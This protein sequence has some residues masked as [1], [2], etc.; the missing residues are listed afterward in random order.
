MVS[1]IC[2]PGAGIEAVT[3]EIANLKDNEERH[4]VVIAGTK[5]EKT[6][7]SEIILKK[8]EQMIKECKKRRSR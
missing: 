3:E 4:L 8:Y 7:G 6:E 5:N 1:A 2:R